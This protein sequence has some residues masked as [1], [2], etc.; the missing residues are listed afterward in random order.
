VVCH[1]LEGVR[2]DECRLMKE[3]EIQNP[4]RN[5]DRIGRESVVRGSVSES[6]W[7]EWT[8]IV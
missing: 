5:S 1:K 6:G 4:L 2:F 8:H 3:S 7:K